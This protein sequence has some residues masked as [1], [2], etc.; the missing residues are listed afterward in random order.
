MRRWF[1]LLFVLLALPVLTASPRPAGVSN[2][3]ILITLDGA[4]TE[5]IFGGLDLRVVRP[6]LKG[7]RVER[8]PFY[9][10]FWAPTPEARRER[11][12]PFFWGTLMR[13][14]GSIAGNPR[15]DS[16]VSL[17]NR[18]RF[19]YPGYAELLL[20]RPHDDTIASNEPVRILYPTI[21]EFVKD[22][23]SLTREQV[24]VF[25]SWGVFN[26]IAEHARGSITINA[27]PERYESMDPSV[28]QT[29]AMQ[30]KARSPWPE[31]R[32]DGFTFR[33]AMDH[34]ARH[35]PRLL[36]LALGEPDDWSHAGRY[37]RVLQSYASTDRALRD[38]W[39][40]LQSQ[41][42]YRDRTTLIITTDHGRGMA[43][44]DW[45]HHGHMVKGSERTWLA[46]VSPHSARRGEWRD[47]PAISSSQV[48]AT[49]IQSLGLDWKAFDSE[50]A[51][52][53]QG[54]M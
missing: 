53:I 45:Q 29:N 7:S 30:F 39:V 33:F 50:M 18:H 52:P 1:I 20:G 54:A 3:A 5:E 9:G 2:A 42:D 11:L 6:A 22:Q 25:A 49:V 40:W 51:P 21:L 47:H 12:L 48:A 37:D 27:G 10:R 36:Y 34:L 19:S 15:L 46:I 23:A 28:Q 35:R 26:A 14:H 43:P 17:S 16:R 41:P 8:H 44:R 24:A 32:H 38:L 31:M 13:S 4:R